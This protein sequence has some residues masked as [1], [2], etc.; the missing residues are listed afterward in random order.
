MV[1]INQQTMFY[2]AA[3]ILPNSTRIFFFCRTN[4]NVYLCINLIE[5]KFNPLN[6]IIYLQ[7]LIIA[8]AKDVMIRTVSVV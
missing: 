6:K 2:N 3:F 1:I 7:E 4:S 8:D 5:R